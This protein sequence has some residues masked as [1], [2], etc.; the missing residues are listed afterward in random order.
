MSKYLTKQAGVQDVDLSDGWDD[1]IPR[2]WWNASD[3]ARA[4]VEGCLFKLSPAFAAFIVQRQ[5]QLEN[6]LLG[7]AGTVTVGYRK[8]ITGD[9]PIEFTRFSFFSTETLM[10]AIEWYC[11]WC[12]DPSVAITGGPTDVP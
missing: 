3:E 12:D 10:I 7:K 1:C 9:F 5:I 11:L 6:A 2:Q 4:L 8:T